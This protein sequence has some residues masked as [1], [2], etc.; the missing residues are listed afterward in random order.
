MSADDLRTNALKEIDRLNAEAMT[1]ACSVRAG[2]HGGSDQLA[3]V[4]VE[5][6]SMARAYATC[7]EILNTEFRKLV[8][9]VSAPGPK[10]VREVY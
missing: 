8:T 7:A 3:L 9:P 10:K 2:T 1:A 6:L 4:V 5:H